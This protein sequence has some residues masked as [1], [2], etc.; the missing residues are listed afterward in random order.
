MYKLLIIACLVYLVTV[1]TRRVFVDREHRWPADLRVFLGLAVIIVLLYA[2]GRIADW[3]AMNTS[4]RDDSITILPVAGLIFGGI[5]GFVTFMSSHKRRWWYW[6]LPPVITVVVIGLI[7][8]G[9]TVKIVGDLTA[10]LDIPAFAILMGYL[11]PGMA[12][13]ANLAY[14]IRRHWWDDRSGCREES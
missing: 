13:G 4:L 6:L 11:L 10:N 8:L 3:G 9:S 12:G 1:L 7:G 5:A 2:L 14:M